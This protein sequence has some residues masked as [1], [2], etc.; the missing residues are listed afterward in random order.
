[1]GHLGGYRAGGDAATFYPELWT[2]LVHELGLRSVIDVGCGEGHSTDYFAHEIET[3][4]RLRGGYVM[5]VDGVPQPDNSRVSL[6]DY[7]EGPLIPGCAI[8]DLC[9]CCE[10]VEHVEEQYVPNFLV[11]FEHADV[12]LMTHA[13]PGQQGYHHV[14]LQ[15]MGY[16]VRRVE[17]ETSLEFDPELTRLTRA[18]ASA[19]PSPWNHYRRSGLA[20]R[21]RLEA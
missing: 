3:K 21:R 16:W 10:F 13:E 1:M 19:N 12:L 9:W 14:N 5:G 8:F 11:T 6:H 20:F 4:T 18:L 7:T 17:E 15:T 2:W